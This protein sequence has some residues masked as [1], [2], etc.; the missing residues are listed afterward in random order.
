MDMD[1]SSLEGPPINDPRFTIP[2]PSPRRRYM[3]IP[4]VQLEHVSL[5]QTPLDRTHHQQRGI[6]PPRPSSAGSLLPQ[7]KH[8]SRDRAHHARCNR[9]NGNLHPTWPC[10]HHLSPDTVHLHP[11]EARLQSQR[12]YQL[13]WLESERIWAMVECSSSSGCPDRSESPSPP[14]P[15]PANSVPAS[16]VS[17]ATIP[18]NASTTTLAPPP[19]VTSPPRYPLPSL[20]HTQS[21]DDRLWEDMLDQGKEG[22][23]SYENHYYDRFVPP[24]RSAVRESRWTEIARRINRVVG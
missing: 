24:M 21:M 17:S 11:S 6:I 13:V 23:P 20:I 1:L 16:P 19:T 5:A 8:S 9:S 2:S 12:V 15:R 4:R 7:N 22:P 18:S 3:N 10:G 14:L